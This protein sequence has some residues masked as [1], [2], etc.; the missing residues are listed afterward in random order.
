MV[1]LCFPHGKAEC[2]AYHN[3]RLIRLSVGLALNAVRFP[4]RRCTASLKH[5]PSCYFDAH[6]VIAHIEDYAERNIIRHDQVPALYTRKKPS[7]ALAI[8]SADSAVKMAQDLACGRPIVV[9]L[10][11]AEEAHAH[12]DSPSTELLLLQKRMVCDMVTCWML[13][14]SR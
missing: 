4:H 13:D 1:N 5:Q 7:R 3:D 14:T 10:L 9:R 8:V 12:I 2:G 11:Q 6:E